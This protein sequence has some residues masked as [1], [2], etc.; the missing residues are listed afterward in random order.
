MAGIIGVG[1]SHVIVDLL[2]SLIDPHLR[3]MVAGIVVS[4]VATLFAVPFFEKYIK[5]HEKSEAHDDKKKNYK[6]Q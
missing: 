2:A 1:L 6:P 5:N 4:G 3:E